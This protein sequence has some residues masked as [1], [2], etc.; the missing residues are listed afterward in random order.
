MLK[1][2][3]SDALIDVPRV[4]TVDGLNPAEIVQIDTCTVRGHAVPWRSRITVQADASGVIDLS[5]DAP[6][7]GSYRGVDSMGWCWS[8]VPDE[9]G[10][11]DLFPDHVQEPLHTRITVVR[12]Q[13]P[14][15][16]GDLVQRLAAAGV[17]RHEVRDNG[18]V[19]TVFTPATPGPHPA[20]L[21]LN[22]SGG[23]INEPRAALWASH[24]FTAFAL[25]Y[26]K[27]PGL[28]P[29]ISNTPL[30]YFEVGLQWL[31]TRYAPLGD[32][33]AIAGQSR[34]GELV[35]LLGSLFP[36]QVSAVLGYVPSA[37]VNCAQNACDPALGREGFAWLYQ[38]KG[39]PHVWADNATASWA[40]W[41]TGPEPRRHTD[42]LLTSLDD[43]AAVERARIAVE[44]LQCPVLLLSGGDDG[45]WPSTRY[46]HMV[47]ESL[48]DHPYDVEHHDYPLAGHSILFP[49]VP[50]TQLEY[51]HPVSGRVSTSGGSPAVNAQADQHSWQAALAFTRK[52][53][54]D[55]LSR[56]T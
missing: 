48:R 22:G 28:S 29:Y 25:G 53:V 8:Q 7:S 12:E 19:G 3:P 32:F 5:R 13:G 26:F 18:L 27:A 35:L 50:T 36:E 47:T 43:P 33:V 49:Y 42:A 21:I 41:D 17:Q 9:T 38:G 1:I 20:I 31:R 34:G 44:K 51:R 4:I 24:G 45:S 46:C 30:E 23:G 54:N 55:T 39:I 6:L 52:A 37:V 10:A 11:R 56:N 40:P 14:T 15:W 2:E 16:E